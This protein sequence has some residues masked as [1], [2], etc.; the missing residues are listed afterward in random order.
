V[1]QALRMDG[2]ESESS[3]LD[4]RLP[5]PHRKRPQDHSSLKSTINHRSFTSDRG[6]NT[7]S[8]KSDPHSGHNA[9]L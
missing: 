2:R 1:V 4:T 8:R 9:A 6:E 7:S 3:R 5:R